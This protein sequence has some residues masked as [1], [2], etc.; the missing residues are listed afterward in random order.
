M[1][2]IYDAQHE[3]AERF[4]PSAMPT[5]YVVDRKGIIRHVHDGYRAGD[6][7]KLER[8]VRALLGLDKG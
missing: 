7:K 1:E 2:S 8:E 3:V 5:S 6:G 4:K